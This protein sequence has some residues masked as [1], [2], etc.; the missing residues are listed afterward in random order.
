[1]AATRSMRVLGRIAAKSSFSSPKLRADV[2]VRWRA[3][4]DPQSDPTEFFPRLRGLEAKWL[5][6]MLLKS[7]SPVHIPERI[8]MQHF[9]F[10][11]PDLLG[12]QDSFEAAVE[13]LREPTIIRISA[14]SPDA[15]AQM[16]LLGGLM[17]EPPHLP[18]CW[19]PGRRIDL[20]PLAFSL[21]ENRLP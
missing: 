14:L 16:L 7:Y 17:I 20:I 6:R 8:A 5:V 10:H 4:T 19:P 2:R 18:A 1:M 9:H 13:L 3:P 12:I 11:L 21:F 15:G